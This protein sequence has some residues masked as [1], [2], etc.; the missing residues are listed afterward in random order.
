LAVTPASAA[1]DDGQT[2]APVPRD[3]DPALVPDAILSGPVRL[4]GE[5]DPD[6]ARRREREQL[7]AW[8]NLGANLAIALTPLVEAMAQAATLWAEAT[9]RLV[10]D[11]GRPVPGEQ[12]R[13]TRYQRHRAR[14]AAT[15][16]HGKR[17]RRRG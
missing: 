1:R 11:L 9:T 15:P 17:D 16:R 3:G 10:R 5:H 6:A 2:T 8:E 13:P 12:Y 14:V 7:M 4:T